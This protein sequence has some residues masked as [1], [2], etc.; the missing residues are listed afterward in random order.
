M[1]IRH[2]L[3]AAGVLALT[4]LASGTAYAA[5]QK[6]A[7]SVPAFYRLSVVPGSLKDPH[8]P[9]EWNRVRHASLRCNPPWGDH[10][11]PGRACDLIARYGSI[12]GI[13]LQGICPHI[14]DPVTAFANGSERYQETFPNACV[15]RTTKGA[16]F[17][18]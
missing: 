6:T 12:A 13:R 7:R 8:R 4:V 9:L 17:H 3:G 14:Y 18:F 10:P 5:P 2:A 1:R 11:Q 16:V 15:L